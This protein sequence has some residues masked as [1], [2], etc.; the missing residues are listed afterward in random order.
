MTQSN[1]TEFANL[2]EEELAKSKAENIE[3]IDLSGKGAICDIMYVASGSSNRTVKFI[4]ER[5]EKAFKERSINVNVEGDDTCQW[6]L[7]DTGPVIVH[8]L[9]PEAREYYNLEE[10]WKKIAR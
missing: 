10:L 5:I 1:V 9:Q 7:V 4:A 8:I 2:I 6:V 3:K